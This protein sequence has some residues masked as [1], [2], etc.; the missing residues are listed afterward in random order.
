MA[1]TGE[2]IAGYQ[3]F[4]DGYYRQ[5]RE[6]LLT[7]AQEGQFPRIA[8][9][10]CCDARVEPSIIFDCAPG[11]L[12]VIRN[13]ANLV[14]PCESNDS[15]HGTSAALEFAV[16]TLEVESIVVLGHTHCGGIKALM[17]HPPL[18]ASKTFISTWMKQLENV[19]N[20]VLGDTALISRE[21][22]YHACEQQGILQSLRNM[23]SFPWIQSR[24]NA[25]KLM[26]HGW[27][28]DLTS[29]ELFALRLDT[30]KFH[31]IS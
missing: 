31:K 7:L 14:P 6:L 5:S 12:F 8:L 11:D 29:A 17:D 21:Q 13:V 3:R 4:R 15:F 2:L 24:I 16:S 9:V 26:L 18:A 20:A 23:H 10:S 25:G 1:A 30:G 22:R 28:Y 19:R 27:Y